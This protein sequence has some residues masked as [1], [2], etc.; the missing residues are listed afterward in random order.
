M[1]KFGR[2]RF[3]GVIGIRVMGGIVLA[4]VEDMRMG[5]M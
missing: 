4:E 3:V 5:K 2:Q 1:E